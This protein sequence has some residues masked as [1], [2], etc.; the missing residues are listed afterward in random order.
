MICVETVA[1]LEKIPNPQNGET[2]I[3][4]GT[5]AYY[6]QEGWK[7]ATF[8]DS[9]LSV[10]LYDLNKTAIPQLPPL[11]QEQLD[12]IPELLNTF[13][14]ECRNTFYMLY[15]KEISYFTLF[16]KNSDMTNETFAEVVLDC[17][18][19]VGSIRAIDLVDVGDAIE[20]WVVN[21]NNEATCLYLFPYDLGVVPFNG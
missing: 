17:L 6:Y 2:A 8:E 18:R 21:E 3:V 5:T 9:N 7:I 10:S 1:D 16:V 13:C 4:G 15:G 11:T 14:E 20:I 12:K 19:M